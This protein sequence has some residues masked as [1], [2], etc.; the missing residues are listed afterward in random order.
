MKRAMLSLFVASLLLFSCS[1]DDG[2]G[3]TEMPE[4]ISL[5]GV[6][7]FTELNIDDVETDQQIRLAN[8]VI[9]VLVAQGCDILTFDFKAD[10]SVTASYRDFTE[11]GRDVNPDGSGLLIEC[12]DTV[13]TSSSVWSLEGDQLTFVN[14]DM[15]EETVTIELTATQLIVPAE[16]LDENNLMGAKAIFDRQ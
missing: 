4:E 5:V 12:P 15:T 3:A 10:E 7:E 16:L 11:T 1:S 14:E 8:D 2:D 13:E 6:W 9:E